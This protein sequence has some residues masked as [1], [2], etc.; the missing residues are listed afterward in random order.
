MIPFWSHTIECIYI[1]SS[2]WTFFLKIRLHFD[3]CFFREYRYRFTEVDLLYLHQKFQWT[4]SFSTR[5]TM[6]NILLRRYDKW[7]WFLT[8]KR[9]E[10]FI[11]DTR[12]FH[13][14]IS[15]DDIEDIDTRFDVLRERHDY[16]LMMNS[17]LSRFDDTRVSQNGENEIATSWTRH[18]WMSRSTASFF[19]SPAIMTFMRRVSSFDEFSRS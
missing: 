10:C 16:L 8:M 6:S 12:F 11:V 4:T 1:T 5:K 3:S 18:S 19:V 13:I 17:I 2:I 14:H 15:P 7:R 9:A